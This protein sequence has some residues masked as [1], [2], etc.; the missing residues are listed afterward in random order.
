MAKI[1]VSFKKKEQDL[2]D[3]VMAQGDHSNFIKDALKQYISQDSHTKQV[4]DIDGDDEN[5]IVD[6]MGL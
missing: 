1:L 6:I 5:G 2:Y 4:T 3:W